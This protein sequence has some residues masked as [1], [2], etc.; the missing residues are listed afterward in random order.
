MLGGSMAFAAGAM[1]YIVNDEL[2]PQSNEQSSVKRRSDRRPAAGLRTV[3]G[4]FP[5]PLFLQPAAHQDAF[6]RLG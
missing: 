6:V 4:L 5:S 1:V 3:V 2:I